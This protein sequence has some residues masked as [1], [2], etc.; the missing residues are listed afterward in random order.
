M[1]LVDDAQWLDRASAQALAFVA[2]RLLAERS[3]W[4]SP[5]REPG[6]GAS[7]V[8]RSCWSRGS[9]RR[10]ARRCCGSVAAGPARRADPRPDRRRDA[11][12][13]ARAAGAAAGLD[14][15]GAGGRIRGARRRA[16]VRPDRAELP[17]AIRVAARATPSSCA[18]AAAEPSGDRTLLWRA[19]ERLG[20]ERPKRSRRRVR[21]TDRR[22][23]PGCGS[24]TRWCARRCT[25]RQPVERREVHRALAEATDP[26]GI[27]I[28]A[29]G[30]AR[31]LPPG[32][33]RR[34]PMSWNARPTAPGAAAALRPRPRSWSER[35]S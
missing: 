14:A 30:I 2:R 8:C 27:R 5:S 12:Q 10:R 11:R 28:A 4:C 26:A 33:T 24:A 9:R 21:R 20:I 34:S 7:P 3:R 23:A 22:S 35:P 19:A 1:C 32:S 13:S 29:H 17:A 18:V 6:R 31:T 16:A 25:G 15:G